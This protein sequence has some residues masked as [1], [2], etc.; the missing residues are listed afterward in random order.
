M[1]TREVRYIPSTYKCLAVAVCCATFSQA[2]FALA[3]CR[4]KSELPAVSGTVV[5]VDTV[6]ALESAV[7]NLQDGT[8][9]LLKPGVYNLSN[10]L[11]IRKK[12]VVLRGDGAS[13]E[14]V[15][16]A[17][18]GMDNANYGNVPHGVWSDAVGLTI[19]NLTIKDVYQHA[20][21]LNQGAQLPVINSVQL[22]NSGQQFIKANPTQYGIGVDGGTVVNSRFAYT[23]GTPAT[24]HGSGVGYTNG[25]DVHAGRNWR[26]ASNTFE[27]F[28][29]PDSS[30]WHWNPAIL[31]WN[32]ASG[33]IAENNIFKDVDR[34][35]A[36]GLED[37][38]ASP[39]HSGGVIRNNMVYYSVG[40]YSATR[41][42]NS[43]GSIIV[44]NSPSTM[45]VHNTVV[46]NGN[47]NKSIEFRFANTVG[48][49]AVNNLVDAPI[50]SR[51]SAVF[52]QSG[53]FTSAV[54]SFFKNPMVGD[55]RLVGAAT[56][57]IDKVSAST[58]APLDVDNNERGP[59]GTVDI[60]A[61]EFGLVSPPAPPTNVRGSQL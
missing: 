23:N 38:G 16:L 45:V 6:G 2:A 57:A 18:K 53:N 30:A 34:A 11:Y 12:N 41:K 4:A 59:A 40:L 42:Y 35:I 10:T 46:T 49:Q 21:I 44:W 58:S 51:N 24:N 56:A 19:T 48:A 61:H 1:Q 5:N 33:T 32:G 14:E 7:S 43:D 39:D 15:V 31:V 9:I 29:T 54:S 28:H 13:C 55:L 26:I 8:T 37:R 47:L 3:P 52:F 22:L 60:G 20:I 36:F 17:G 27:S 50:G 25:V